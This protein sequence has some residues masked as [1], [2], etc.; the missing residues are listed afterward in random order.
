MWRGPSSLNTA[1]TDKC[2]GWVW[3]QVPLL[4]WKYHETDG[5]RCLNALTVS[6]H[7]CWDQHLWC[8]PI[9]FFEPNYII[10]SPL[11]TQPRILLLLFSLIINVFRQKMNRKTHIYTVS[12]DLVSNSLGQIKR[13]NS[14]ISSLIIWSRLHHPVFT[15][16]G[17]IC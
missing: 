6:S 4:K 2:A 14:D 11:S 3:I 16:T 1:Y 15:E 12:I 5:N 9:H 8:T 13:E 7:N 10:D 17:C